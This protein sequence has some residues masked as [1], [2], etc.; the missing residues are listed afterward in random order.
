MIERRRIVT[1]VLSGAIIAVVAVLV[2]GVCAPLMT[3]LS[4]NHFSWT[5]YATVVYPSTETGDLGDPACSDGIDNDNDG[6]TDCADRDCLGVPPCAAAAPAI[7]RAGLLLLAG[8]FTAIG[9]VRLRSR[10]QR[11]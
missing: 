7:S 2:S 10:R 4:Y 3:G 9:A 1:R 8:L 6:L 11:L 5:A